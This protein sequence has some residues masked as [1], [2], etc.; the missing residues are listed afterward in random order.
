LNDLLKDIGEVLNDLLN[1]VMFSFVGTLA[2]SGWILLRR[3]HKIVNRNTEAQFNRVDE[4]IQTMNSN[5]EKLIAMINTNLDEKIKPLT[6]QV[7]ETT[8][9][10]LRMNL[11]DGMDSNRL[12]VSEVS[13]FYDKYKSLGGNSFVTKKVYDYIAKKENPDELE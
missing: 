9:E 11:L 5:N 6:K 3:I 7:N 1:P 10:V 13:F 4:Q 2:T 8:K 12:S